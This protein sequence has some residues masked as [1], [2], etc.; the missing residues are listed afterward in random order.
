MD[1][2]DG[3]AEQLDFSLDQRHPQSPECRYAAAVAGPGDLDRPWAELPAFTRG[4]DVFGT[5]RSPKEPWYYLRAICNP[6]RSA[7]PRAWVEWRTRH[8]HPQV[9]MV[10]P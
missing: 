3:L 6:R 4:A 10:E 7:D 5:D 9:W 8:D 1:E 2:I